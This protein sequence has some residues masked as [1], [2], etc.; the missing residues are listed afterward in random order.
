MTSIQKEIIK[1][2]GLYN[3]DVQKLSSYLKE[4]KNNSIKKL[5]IFEVNNENEYIAGKIKEVKEKITN[6][7]ESNCSDNTI[8]KFLTLTELVDEL[9]N[10]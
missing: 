5:S 10:Q 6:I 2:Y 8:I 7:N 3:Q 4:I 1:N 9:D